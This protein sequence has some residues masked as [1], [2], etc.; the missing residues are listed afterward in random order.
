MNPYLL[1]LK[2]AALMLLMPYAMPSVIE[3][4]AEKEAMSPYLQWMMIG[5][6]AIF[7]LYSLRCL[8]SRR[9]PP[10]RKR[11]LLTALVALVLTVRLALELARVGYVVL[12][13][14]FDLS[15]E[16]LYWDDDVLLPLF[17][18]DAAHLSFFCG[19]VGVCLSV[20]LANCIT[21]RGKGAVTAGM[22]AF[23]PFGALMVVLFRL[24]Q[25]FEPALHSHG[26][27]KPLP[28]GSSLAR[29]PF[30]VDI[31]IAGGYTGWVWNIA[32]MSAVFAFIW[33]AVAFYISLRGRGRRG[34]VFTLTLFFLCLPQVMCESMRGNDIKWLFVHVE[35]LFCVLVLLGVLLYWIIG[36]KGVPLLRRWAPLLILAAGCGLIVVAEFAI[37]GKWFDFSHTICYIFMAVVLAGMGFAGGWAARN[38]NRSSQAAE[39][40]AESKY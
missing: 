37:D 8:L 6:L 20:W 9:E 27:G 29:F 3:R 25:A 38:W 15:E 21:R 23:A 4:E 2:T 22:D 31:E 17:T 39:S 19:A 5:T 18:F 26:G 1:Q 16:G 14:A 28:A 13:E 30:A 40:A 12:S 33:A 32:L 10:V 7:A 35:Q 11:A 36:S 24:G 34:L